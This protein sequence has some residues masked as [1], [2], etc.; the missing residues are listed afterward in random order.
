MSFKSTV[1]PESLLHHIHTCCTLLQ[2]D[3]ELFYKFSP[4]LI[5]Y[6]PVDTVSAWIKQGK[7]LEAKRLI[8]ALVQYEHEKYREQVN[9]CYVNRCYVNRCYVNIC[10]VNICYVNMCYVYRCFSEEVKNYEKRKKLNSMLE[11]DLQIRLH[12]R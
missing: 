11:T 10:Y 7:K 4:L 3:V 12:N 1:F 5:Q 6:T 9:R 8:P 2:T